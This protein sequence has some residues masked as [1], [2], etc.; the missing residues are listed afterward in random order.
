MGRFLR[1]LV[2]KKKRRFVDRADGFDLDLAYI[3]DSLIAMGFPS[4]R[5]P[6]RF[7]RNDMREVQ[8]FL[9]SRHPDAY[10]VYNLC[11]ERDYD[12]ACFHNRVSVFPFDDHNPPPFH[13]I[14]LLCADVSDWLSGTS[15]SP[16]FTAGP[17]P[18]SLSSPPSSSSAAPSPSSQPPP[19]VAA[20]HCKAGKG[21]TGLMICCYLLHSGVCPT[22]DAALRFYG[23]RRTLDGNGVTLLSQ[24]RYVGY[25]E[26]FLRETAAGAAPER[27]LGNG[28]TGSV[29]ARVVGLWVK[30][31][32][33]A[34]LKRASPYFVIR[35][36]D[37][38]VWFRSAAELATP[39]PPADRAQ[40][41]ESTAPAAPRHPTVLAWQWNA[42]SSNADTAAD[43]TDDDA[44]A[45]AAGGDACLHVPRHSHL[46][47]P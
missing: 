11:S 13:L 38:V 36:R 5:S 15:A 32:P 47:L 42:P 10:K 22:A 45:A 19:R 16:P 9:D 20:I 25:Y 24:R 31:C 39:S 29:R 23:D 46:G 6:D 2:S 44:A 41:A 33:E 30:G 37:G 14:P 4:T 35:T 18:S 26:R 12:H 43:S 40:S 1:R 34:W 3:T 7:Y 8:R 21:R 28:G 27:W 17:L